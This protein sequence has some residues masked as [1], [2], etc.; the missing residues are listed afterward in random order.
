MKESTRKLIDQIDADHDW[1]NGQTYGGS[2]TQL[3]QT[4]TC[5]VCSLRRHWFSD[6]QN[7]IEDSYRWSDGET[8]EDLSLR[9]AAARGCA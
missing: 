9:Q 6:S 4:D 8:D 1:Q 7:G 5:R 3:S 2:G